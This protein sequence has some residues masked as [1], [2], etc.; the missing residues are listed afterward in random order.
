MY[1]VYLSAYL[2]IKGVSSVINKPEKMHVQGGPK[3]HFLKCQYIVLKS[4][5]SMPIRIDFKSTRTVKQVL[6]IVVT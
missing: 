5:K 4:Y 6:Y 3:G 2:R 1:R